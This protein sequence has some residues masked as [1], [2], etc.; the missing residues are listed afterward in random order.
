MKSDAPSEWLVGGE[1]DEGNRMDSLVGVVDTL[2]EEPLSSH[3]PCLGHQEPVSRLPGVDR[4]GI[5]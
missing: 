3:S 1:G 4:R 2:V 5:A